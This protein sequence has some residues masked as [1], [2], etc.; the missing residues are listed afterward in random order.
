MH[1]V[2]FEDVCHPCL[3]CNS[4]RVDHLG[5]LCWSL[6]DSATG[7]AETAAE[8]AA[9]ATEKGP[10]PRIVTGLQVRL[11]MLLCVF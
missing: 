6:Y 5:R 1:D 2:I 3:F 11:Q 4:L 10:I 7:D 8:S 9:C